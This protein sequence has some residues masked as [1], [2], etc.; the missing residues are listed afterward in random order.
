[1]PDP[2]TF[3]VLPWSPQSGW[4]LCD[5]CASAAAEELAFCSRSFLKK[6][7]AAFAADNMA[8]RCGLEF[9]FHVFRIDDP[10]L[11]HADAGMPANPPKTSLIAHGYQ[12]LTEARYDALE[13]VM[14]DLRRAA[15][16]LRLPVRTME[17]EF[18][19]SQC[20]FTFKFPAARWSR[21]TT[22]FC[23]ARW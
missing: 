20:E 5:I 11:A 6:A 10:H 21:P 12:Y 15:Q 23:S 14:D 7:V 13:E 19:P 17:A 22:A 4:L 3:R 18:G 9:E 8:L 16:A 1:M 2:A